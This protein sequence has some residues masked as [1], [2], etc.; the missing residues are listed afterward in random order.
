MAVNAFTFT[1]SAVLLA[2][3]PLDGRLARAGTSLLASLRSGTREIVARPGVKHA[4]GLLD[5]GRGR[6]RDG[7]RRR[8]HAR[9]RAAR[10]RRLRPRRAD[11][12]LRHR[13]LPRLDLRDAHRHHLAVAQGLHARARV[14]G[15]RPDPVRRRAVLLAHAG[16]VRARRL[17]QRPRAR[18]RPPAAGPRGARG[19]ARPAV[20]AAQDLHLGRL[21]HRLRPGRR[22][23]LHARGPG[24]VP[25][26][27]AVADRHH[28]GRATPPQSAVAGTRGRA[29]GAPLPVPQPGTT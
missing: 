4:A 3:I 5:G 13:D 26:C 12:R 19:A 11:D 29:G 14:H 1:I 28:P 20:R 16:D 7:Q 18:A 6:R 25:V 21:R 24:D 17:R 2:T 27:G 22:A 8:G 23:D 9:P 15:R 10:R